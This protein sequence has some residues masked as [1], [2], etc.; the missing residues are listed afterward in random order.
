MERL[1]LISDVSAA[2]SGG[3]EHYEDL[4]RGYD[5]LNGT[6]I[7]WEADPDYIERLKRFQ[8]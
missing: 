8:K 3:K 6:L 4:K 1:Q 5:Q 2:F 7:K